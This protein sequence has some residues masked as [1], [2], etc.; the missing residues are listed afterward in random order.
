MQPVIRRNT[1]L[2]IVLLLVG[3]VLH[4]IDPTENLLLNSFL[5]CAVYTIYIGLIL[6]WILSVRE[7]L[8]PT[9]VRSC[10]IAAGILMITGLQKTVWA[11]AGW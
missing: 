5:F 3:G 10:M 6:F 8:L 11:T 4:Y 9:K 1:R 2:F 7:R